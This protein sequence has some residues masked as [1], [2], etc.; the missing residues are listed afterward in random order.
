M[1]RIRKVPSL[2]PLGGYVEVEEEWRLLGGEAANTANALRS[3]DDEVLI[4]GNP[5]GDSSEGRML[6]RMLTERDLELLELANPT[7]AGEPLATPVCD[8]Y[9]TADGDRTMF[10]RGFADMESYT[11][12]D[13]VPWSAG[14]WFTAEPNKAHLTREA[15]AR[16]HQHGM[17]LYL[18]DFIRKD[19]PI[20]PGSFWQS[21]TDWAGHRNN[22]QRNVAWVKDW[23]ARHGCYAVLS[24]GPNGF[25]AGS[26]ELPI[27]AYPPF[28]A[29]SVVDT[30]GAGDSFRAGM[31]HGLSR[32]WPVPD[33][34]R[35]ASAAGCLKV[36]TLGAT[37]GVPSIVEIE[38]HLRDNPDVARQYG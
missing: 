20:Y 2:P 1:D 18:M 35:F 17:R 19:D 21:S 37:V 12:L 14:V 27:R 16:A 30:T 9:V 8:I 15:A 7:A 4:A 24:D 31:L 29:P 13:K 23:V 5:L 10:G 11:S 34:L 32:G 22:V 26:A 25:V 36:R 33:C 38:A 3:W 28:P 6:R